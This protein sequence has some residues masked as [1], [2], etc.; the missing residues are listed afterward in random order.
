MNGQVWGTTWYRFR[1]TFRRRSGG[2]LTVILLIGLLGGLAMGAI[3]GARR[4]QSSFSTYLTS[5]N[6]SDLEVDV[7]PH[8]GTPPPASSAYY[9][10]LA[11]DF[12][13]LPDVKRVASYDAGIFA[14]PLDKDGAPHLPAAI[15]DGDVDTIGSVNGEYFTQD[16]VAV[17]QGR[18]ANPGRANE[19]VASAEAAHLLGWHVGEVVP[20]GFYT[21]QQ[22]TATPGFGT[23]KVRPYLRISATLTGIVVFQ[24][25]VVSDDV[26]R[27]PTNVLF[28]PALTKRIAHA[29]YYPIFDLRLDRPSDVTAVEQRIIGLLPR[30]TTYNVHLTSVVEGEVQRA[31]KPEGIALGVFGAI[32]GLAALLIAGQAI[33]RGLQINGEDL[34][35]LRALGAAPQTAIAD[36][37]LGVFGAVLVGSL[38]AAGVAVGLSP[39]APIGPV[40]QVD[41]SPGFAFDWTVLAAGLAVLILG[42]GA[43]TVALSYWGSPHRRAARRRGRPTERASSIA[44]VAARAGVPAT[45]VT[46]IRFALERGHGRTAVPVRSALFGAVLAVVVV[47]ATVTFASGLNTLVSHPRLYGWNWNYAIDEV[48]GGNIPPRTEALLTHDRDVAAWAGFN[49]ASVIFDGQTVPVL[50][51]SARAAVTPPI[52]SGHAVEANNQIVLGAATLAQ[53]HKKIGDTIIATF[54]TPK[55]APLYIPPTPLVIVGTA[56]LPAIGETGTLHTS[57]GTGALISGG[58]EPA[59]FQKAL[60]SPDPNLNG[61][62][63]E[64]AVRLRRG[65]NPA[66][67]LASLQ[68]IA[69]TTTKFMDADPNGGGTFAVLP[70]QRPAEIVNYQSSGATPAVLAA[71]VAGGAVAGLGLTLVASVRR[72]RRDLALL[73][74]LGFTQRQLAATIAWQASVAAVI[75]IVVGVP[76]GIALGRWLWVLFAHQIY[77]VADPTVPVTQ[78]VLIAVGALALTNLIAALPGRLAARTPTALLLRTE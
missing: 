77:A 32:A 57:M 59:A 35:V 66:A 39:L 30:G 73:K 51:S 20:L 49:F 19:F 76:L 52:L 53:L 46:G 26:D 74:T 23:A 67:G 36:G 8:S 18:L 24:S 11:T 33:G 56:T 54:G 42:L 3:A 63:Y 22:V 12:A 45:A 37:L 27:F 31:I 17:T 40:R 62:Y 47:V 6:S 65:V 61:P 2:Y 68:R 1:A 9:R 60:K 4:T 5:T 25:E 44:G 14:A 72:R 64:L 28:T 38:V 71:A 70:V 69:K 55:D 7:Y 29:A 43:L 78:V 34:E 58:I 75:G 21:Y 10:R 50:V 16:R 41:P 13:H 48:G 15:N